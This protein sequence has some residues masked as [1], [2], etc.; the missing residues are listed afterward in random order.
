MQLVNLGQLWSRFKIP[1]LVVIGG[2][3][4]LLSLRSRQQAAQAA[5][6]AA[7]PPA[8]GGDPNA[9]YQAGIAQGAGLY[10]QGVAQGLAPTESA[11]GLAGATVGGAVSLAQGAQALAAGVTG[12][13]LGFGSHLIGALSGLLTPV[14]APIAQ[15][16][17][18][19]PAQ[20]TTTRQV[21]L[22]Y[23]VVW[24]PGG[25]ITV[26]SGRCGA[27]QSRVRATLGGTFPVS[28]AVCGTGQVHWRFLS[29]P[30]GGWHL[31]SWA[32]GQAAWRIQKGTRTETLVNGTRTSFTDAWADISRTGS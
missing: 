28:R 17:P 7:A 4:A 18:T 31:L 8:G 16:A 32:P 13:Y 5:A 1:I 21:P 23:R 25:T 3:S 15:P 14:P 29:G 12:D 6:A 27:W 22:G 9:A 20:Q 2:G 26:H 24:P 10:G 11:L 19:A 30:Y